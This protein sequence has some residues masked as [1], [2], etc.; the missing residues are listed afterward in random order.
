M[1][2]SFRLTLSLFALT[3]ALWP[4]LAL[5]APP[6][7]YTNV[8]RLGVH[9]HWEYPSYLYPGGPAGNWYGYPTYTY[10]YGHPFLWNDDPIYWP[11]TY[12]GA[13]L[14][15]IARRVDPELLGESQRATQPPPPP[16]TLEE[17]AVRSLRR[18]DFPLAATQF[19]RL[20]LER[21]E[22]DWPS[23]P[24]Q[25]GAPVAR[26]LWTLALAGARQFEEAALLLEQFERAAPIVPTVNGAAMTG[27]TE[28][29]RTIVT[30]A[31]TWAHANPSPRAWR[32]VAF[33]MDL[34][35]R[36]APA[37]RMRQRA[38]ELEASPLTAATPPADNARP[39]PAGPAR[40]WMPRP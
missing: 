21:S 10:P 40:Y 25:L 15:E 17:L 39:R 6:T 20:A 36:P 35:N 30:T 32:L 2:A 14:V 27:S 5:A 4:P 8:P 19:A 12:R 9:Y 7:V 26:E 33:L 3:S 31:V 34:D 18:G 23:A 38:D 37:A 1:N 29:M 16:P 11:R 13:P 24:D 28:R 22:N